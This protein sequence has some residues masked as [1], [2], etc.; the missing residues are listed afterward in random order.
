MKRGPSS[1]DFVPPS[2]SLR[3]PATDTFVID[4]M[5]VS[6]FLA[7]LVKLTLS[8][9]KWT[10]TYT[11]SFSHAPL[12]RSELL[13]SCIANSVHV[14]YLKWCKFNVNTL[15]LEHNA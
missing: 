4:Y 6:Q 15:D 9:S 13:E 8:T 11:Q 5:Q 1:R 14:E 12:L 2:F 10:L 7:W 3:L